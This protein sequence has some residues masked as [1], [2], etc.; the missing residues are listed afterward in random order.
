MQDLKEC[1]RL[2]KDVIEGDEDDLQQ[3]CEK[4]F[5]EGAVFRHPFFRIGGREN[6]IRMF[7][8][9]RRCNWKH[10]VTINNLWTNDS[11]VLLDITQT[12]RLYFLPFM[13]GRMQMFVE[14][15]CKQDARSGKWVIVG[16]KDY[17]PVTSLIRLTAPGRFLYDN[18]L[19]VVFTLLFFLFSLLLGI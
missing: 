14:L 16:Q 4:C 9:W 10:S 18:V 5:A 1:R 15:D 19:L 13:E 12:F 2:V 3:A 7:K 8:A 6:M 11:T 17:Y